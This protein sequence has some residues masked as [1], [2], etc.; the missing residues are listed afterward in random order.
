MSGRKESILARPIAPSLEAGQV[1]VVVSAAGVGKSTC[2]VRIALGELVRGGGVLHVCLESPVD[3]VRAAYDVKLDALHAHD[4]EGTPASLRV[5]VERRRMIHSYL[6]NSFSAQKIGD[7]L[8][9]LEEHVGFEPTM[10]VVD[11]FPFADSTPD[12]LEALRNMA[13]G[14]GTGLWA[15]ALSHR[16]ARADA[17]TG[18]PPVLVPFADQLDAVVRLAPEG[19]QIR[20]DLLKDGPT[21][22]VSRLPVHL[23]PQTMLLMHDDGVASA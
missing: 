3:H 9:F 14:A 4:P 2:L 11:G 16:S 12:E 21:L 10:L 19:E 6:R 23:E 1:G 17:Q 20:V 13:E 8:G 7:A 15:S 18:L 5:E 22:G